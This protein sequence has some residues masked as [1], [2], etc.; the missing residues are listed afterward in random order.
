MCHQMWN[1]HFW[2]PKYRKDPDLLEKWWQKKHPKIP[3]S[4]PPCTSQATL[5]FVSFFILCLFILKHCR[6][7]A[8]GLKPRETLCAAPERKGLQG[9]G[10]DFF[11]LCSNSI[12]KH[13]WH[14]NNR[15]CYS[16]T[17]GNDFRSRYDFFIQLPCQKALLEIVFPPCLCL[18]AFVTPAA[19]K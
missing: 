8:Q 13:G 11:F 3:P 15:N 2:S 19:R 1:F 7:T 9:P 4:A 16:F 17:S 12:C 6:G 14:R 18:S 10:G 5:T